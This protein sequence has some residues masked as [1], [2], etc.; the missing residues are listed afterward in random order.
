MVD[1]LPHP[2]AAALEAL[3]SASS[4][5]EQFV[6]LDHLL[7]NTVNYL[8]AVALSQY[9]QDKPDKKK[10]R[11]WL[12]DLTSAH[13]L[14]SLHALN[15]VGDEYQSYPE[16]PYIYP[17]LFERYFAPVDADS[18]IGKTWQIFVRLDRNPK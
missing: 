8:A 13:L 9:W 5:K 1:Y 4:D 2:I 16:K 6:A 18:A 10:L 14:T 12:Q 15:K 7:K 11:L 17:A 3:Q